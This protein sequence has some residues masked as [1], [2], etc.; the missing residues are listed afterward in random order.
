[1][2]YIKPPD[3]ECSDMFMDSFIGG[4]GAILTAIVEFGMLQLTQN[5]YTKTI[6]HQNQNE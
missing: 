6:L 1:M 2:G 4:G 5:I 3:G